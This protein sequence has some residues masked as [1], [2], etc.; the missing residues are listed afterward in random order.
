MVNCE[1]CG[2]EFKQKFKREKYCSRGCYAKSR[3]KPLTKLVCPTCG[4]D[5]YKKGSHIKE[6]KIYFCSR[7]CSSKSRKIYFDEIR[8]CK[9]CGEKFTVKSKS[10][11]RYCCC[12]CAAKGLAQ[13][14]KEK[15]LLVLEREFEIFYNEYLDILSEY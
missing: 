6:G 2:K 12:D 8:A 15:K 5:F 3:T 9:Y 14:K 11:K 10:T 13:E 4:E 7:S 1:Q